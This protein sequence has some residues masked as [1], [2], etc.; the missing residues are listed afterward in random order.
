MD[1][2][3]T[4]LNNAMSYL[5]G[6]LTS[7]INS[8]QKGNML[9]K[10]NA[11]LLQNLIYNPE[12]KQVF[13]QSPLHEKDP[14]KLAMNLIVGMTEP[15]TNKRALFGPPSAYKGEESVIE[16]IVLDVFDKMGNKIKT[17]QAYS[18]MRKAI[19]IAKN[20]LDLPDGGKIFPRRATT[21][22]EAGP[23][24]TQQMIDEARKIIQNTKGGVK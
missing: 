23:Y 13:P 5:S 19:D 20:Y 14:E 3:P 17:T 6:N 15:T 21:L 4:I 12:T 11:E 24:A 22:E 8:Y 2:W 16:P 18:S 9:D 7:A 10:A 1:Q